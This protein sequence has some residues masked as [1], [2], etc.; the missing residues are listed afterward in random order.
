MYTIGIFFSRLW[1]ARVIAILLAICVATALFL[2]LKDV[3]AHQKNN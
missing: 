3:L 1:Y 2:F